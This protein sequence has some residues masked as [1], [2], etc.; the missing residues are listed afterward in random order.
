MESTKTESIQCPT[1]SGESKDYAVWWTRFT[2][3]AMV[4]RFEI[5]ALS[6]STRHVEMPVTH[7]PG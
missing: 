1:F 4:K 3:F 7:A 2:A 5:I 6:G